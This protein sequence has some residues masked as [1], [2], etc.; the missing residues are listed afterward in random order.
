[1]QT[2]FFY[3]SLSPFK[4]TVFTLRVIES[5]NHNRLLCSHLFLTI[6]VSFYDHKV[7]TQ[8]FWTVQKT[9]VTKNKIKNSTT[10]TQPLLTF[11]YVFPCIVNIYVIYIYSTIRIML[12]LFYIIVSLK[13]ILWHFLSLTIILKHYFSSCITFLCINVIT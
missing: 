12:N 10:Q 2:C 8:V 11:Y 7:N 4:G 1:M 6:N 3:I 5:G 13:T 9:E